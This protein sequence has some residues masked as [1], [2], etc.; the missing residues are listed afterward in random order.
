MKTA[1]KKA[2]K[3][4][5]AEAKAEYF[6]F[7]EV[8][9]KVAADL[10]KDRQ[11]EEMAKLSKEL[12]S[13]VM[14]KAK[15]SPKELGKFAKSKGLELKTSEKFNRLSG[16]V[17]GIG[18]VPELINDAFLDK[19]PLADGPKMYD[20]RGTHVIVRGLE[21]FKPELAN[22]AK[23]REKLVQQATSRKEQALFEQWM[24]DAR[25]KAKISTNQTLVQGEEAQQAEE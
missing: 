2:A 21:A 1:A 19:S 23:E 16:F 10:L 8:K 4:G 6:P 17:Q 20:T 11:V 5:E 9:R 24:T 3:K 7:E 12:A 18:D 25:T 13:Q 14:E 22:L 15:S